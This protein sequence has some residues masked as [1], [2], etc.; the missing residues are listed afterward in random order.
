MR[1]REVPRKISLSISNRDLYDFTRRVGVGEVLRGRI[2]ELVSE[3]K[4]IVNFK[5]FN[6]VAETFV[7]R[8]NKRVG[9]AE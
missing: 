9:D 2:R 4:V 5:G 8:M 1:V 3:N 6:L 7:Y